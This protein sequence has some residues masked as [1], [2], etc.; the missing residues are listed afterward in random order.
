MSQKTQGSVTSD[1]LMNFND[2]TAPIRF[3]GE[4]ERRETK[5]LNPHKS[6]KSFQL[7]I[8]PRYPSPPSSSFSFTKL[9]NQYQAIHNCY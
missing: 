2:E 1:S 7:H 9:M 6:F 3:P 4:A 5:P 8:G